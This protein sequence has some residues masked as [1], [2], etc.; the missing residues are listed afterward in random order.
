MNSST[1]K[2]AI[3][4][5]TGYE[6]G[7]VIIVIDLLRRANIVIDLI[8]IEDNL[9]VKSSHNVV[10]L[11]EKTINDI[12]FLNY[13]MLILPGGKVGVENLNKNDLLKSMLVTFT[14][15]N[16]RFIA[17]ICAAPQILGQLKL[18]NNKKITHYPGANVG[19]N[20]S[21]SLNQK[22]VVDG[23]IITGRSI[24][25]TFEFAL[26][27]IEILKNKKISEQIKKQLV[28]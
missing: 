13:K 1:F 25:A 23:N 18:I 6:M 5:A 4:L 9:K 20:E 28:F 22:V 17:A 11:C 10:I 2:V 27:L 7:E 14:K 12:D 21:I 24:A 16:S 26:T 19:L 8:S 3:F 15:D